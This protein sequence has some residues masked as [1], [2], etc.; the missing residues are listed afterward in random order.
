MSAGEVE[1][2]TAHGG[3][4]VGVADG[5]RAW[6]DLETSFGR[7]TNELTPAALSGAG[8]IEAGTTGAGPTG[9]GPTVR[10]TART[11]FGDIRVLR[12]TDDLPEAGP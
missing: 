4:D 2:K 7:V 9:A 6:V 8:P 5:T 12:V 10:L 1:V 3:V 11:S